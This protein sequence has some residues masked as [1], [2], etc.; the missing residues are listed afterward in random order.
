MGRNY[1]NNMKDETNKK[2]V[3]LMCYYYSHNVPE[4]NCTVHPWMSIASA[5]LLGFALARK[6]TTGNE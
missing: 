1:L 4:G 5:K 3:D 2:R 6:K